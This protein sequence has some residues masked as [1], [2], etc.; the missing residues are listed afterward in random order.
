MLSQRICKYKVSE[1]ICEYLCNIEKFR[2]IV[3]TSS[4]GAHVR[5]QWSKSHDTAALT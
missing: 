5:V 4:Q 3:L 2:E 1:V